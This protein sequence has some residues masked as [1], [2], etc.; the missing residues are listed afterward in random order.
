MS[1][2][3]EDAQVNPFFVM[4]DSGTGDKFARA[5]SQKGLGSQGE[6]DWLVKSIVEE[7]RTWGHNGGIS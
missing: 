4:T 1:K 2:A 6:M 5:V 3:D 7:L